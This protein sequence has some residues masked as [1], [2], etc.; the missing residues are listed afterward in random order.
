MTWTGRKV[1]FV[2]GSE[3]LRGT[4]L[5]QSAAGWFATV[6]VE[7]DGAPYSMTV[8]LSDLTIDYDHSG[9]NTGG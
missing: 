2:F 9:N 6:R 8:P 5:S 7:N 1:A 3:T 4:V